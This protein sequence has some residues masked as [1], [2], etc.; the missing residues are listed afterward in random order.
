MASSE[1]NISGV[2][3]V[4]PNDSHLRGKDR[5]LRRELPASD[6]NPHRVNMGAR[7]VNRVGITPENL[8]PSHTITSASGRF[9]LSVND[10]H[11]P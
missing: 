10:G 6:G 2:P 1:I 7:K 3:G 9:G 4:F 11:G 8:T 5:K